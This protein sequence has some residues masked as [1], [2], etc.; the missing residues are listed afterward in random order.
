MNINNLNKQ[1]ISDDFEDYPHPYE[2][3]D[4]G[5]D[6]NDYGDDD[7]DDMEDD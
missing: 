7:D 1:I 2:I 6:F 4:D 5:E 3:N